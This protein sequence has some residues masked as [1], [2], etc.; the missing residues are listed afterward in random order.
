MAVTQEEFEERNLLFEKG[1][2]LAYEEMVR[3]KRSKN[4][5]I[6]TMENGEII[7]KDPFTV[8]LPED[9]K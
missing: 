3:F 9:E 2:R 5:P 4:S 8:P 7:H 1:L 6:V